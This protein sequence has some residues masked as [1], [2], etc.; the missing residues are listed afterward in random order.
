M[1]YSFVLPPPNRVYFWLAV[2]FVLRL[3]A[4]GGL[5]WLGEYSLSDGLLG[6]LATDSQDYLHTSY[7]LAKHGT[8]AKITGIPYAGRTPGYDWV[9]APLLFFFE[10]TTALNIIYL[11][12]WGLATLAAYALALIAYRLFAQKWLFVAVVISYSLN[13]FVAYYDWIILT[14]SFAVSALILGLYFLTGTQSEKALVAASAFFTWAVFLR[15]YLLPLFFLLGVSLLWECRRHWRRA[16]AK[17]IAF[18]SVFVVVE[19]AWIVRNYLHFGRLIPLVTDAHAGLPEGRFLALM[20]FVQAWGGDFVS[21]NPAAEMMLFVDVRTRQTVPNKY[22]QMEDLP[23]YV[24]T[25]AYNADSLRILK[26]WYH[27]ADSAGIS[28]AL[29]RYADSVAYAKLRAYRQAFITE[30]PIYYHIIAPLRLLPKFLLHSGTYNLTPQTFAALSTEKQIFRILYSALYYFVW[31]GGL[32]G[33]LVYITTN[34]RQLSAKDLMLA[35]MALYV[36]LLCPLVLR[37]I[38]Y[39]HF[40]MS[41][42]FLQIYAIVLAGYIYHFIF[43]KSLTPTAD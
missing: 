37:R 24:F 9:I 20:E 11:L 28:P 14:E 36:V 12:Q 42:P 21:W 27:L 1:S 19:T 13:T 29:A 8:Y 2:V 15:P 38:E 41:Y 39:R 5:F 23:D 32:L 30:K 6:N 10:E 22:R 34:R 25:S 16:L 33:L 35:S 7:E 3:I 43:R 18:A 26:K 17:G 4:A 31:T 40:V